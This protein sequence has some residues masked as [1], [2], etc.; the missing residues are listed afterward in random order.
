MEMKTF[1]IEVQELLARVVEVES[2][3]LQ[4]AMTNVQE[5][6]RKAEIVLDYN[7]FVEANFIDLKSQPRNDEM[8]MLIKDV[9]EY[10]YNNEKRYYE[11][12]DERQNYIFSKL[13][14]IKTLID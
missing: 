13:E 6:Y 8:K 4:E 11:E 3:N 9:I 14:R 7:D 1:K 2:N 12:S 5:K 10:L